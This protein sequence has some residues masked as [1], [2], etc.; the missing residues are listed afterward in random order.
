MGSSDLFMKKTVTREENMDFGDTL[1]EILKR[2]KITQ[3]QLAKWTD[4]DCS[5]INRFLSGAYKPEQSSVEAIAYCYGFSDDE[6]IALFRAAGCVPTAMI[7]KFAEDE[8][9]AREC[10]R[11]THKPLG[12]CVHTRQLG[13]YA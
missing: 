8:G 9:F 1:R 3:R 4:L 5:T 7:E 12:V 2:H 13:V 6:R 11:Q 10:W